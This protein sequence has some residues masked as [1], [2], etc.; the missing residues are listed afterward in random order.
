MSGTAYKYV[1]GITT[2][3]GGAGRTNVGRPMLILT[4]TPAAASFVPP[5]TKAIPRRTINPNTPHMFFL[6]FTSLAAEGI[7][8]ISIG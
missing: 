5:N 4:P 2:T 1:P 7:T 6:I 8:V 3:G